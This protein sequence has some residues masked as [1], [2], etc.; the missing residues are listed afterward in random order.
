MLAGGGNTM[1]YPTINK[2]GGNDGTKSTMLLDINVNGTKQD[3][4]TLVDSRNNTRTKTTI[5]LD[6]YT[7]EEAGGWMT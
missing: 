1:S 4:E 3:V 7:I 6:R 2:L 5:D